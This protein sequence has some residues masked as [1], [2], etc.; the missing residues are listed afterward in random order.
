M[1][2]VLPPDLASYSGIISVI[3]LFVD[4]LLF[5]VAIKK[6]IVS[7]ILLV[8]AFALTTYVGLSIPYL[9]SSD[10]ITHVSNIFV[11][12]YAHLGAIFVTYP[13]FFL[14]GLAIGLW[15]G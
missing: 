7:A 5:G 1:G 12:F 2:L 6:A 13:I 3:L 8:V 11:S 15:K 10:I 9:S 4:G 14:I